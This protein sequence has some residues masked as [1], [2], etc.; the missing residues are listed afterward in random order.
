VGG[1]G[2]RTS[3]NPPDP[4]LLDVY[5]RVGV[6]VMDENRLFENNTRF[7]NNMGSLVQYTPYNHTA[8]TVISTICTT[9]AHW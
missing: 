3:H 6:V 7:I 4:R 8:Y 9:W 5:D 2:R 1:N